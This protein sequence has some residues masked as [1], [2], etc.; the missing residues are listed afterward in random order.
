MIERDQ[1][2]AMFADNPKCD[3][4]SSEIGG[5]VETSSLQ[6]SLMETSHVTRLS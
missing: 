4:V 2:A 1:E 5:E 6:T 3:S